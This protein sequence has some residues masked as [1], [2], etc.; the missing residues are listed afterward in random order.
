MSDYT[1]KIKCIVILSDKSSGSS[2]LYRFLSLFPEVNHIKYTRHYENE[3]LYWTKA[4]SILELDQTKMLD[5][6]V[7]INKHQ[8]KYELKKFLKRNLKSFSF[9]KDDKEL[10]F[11]GWR[12]LCEEYAPVFIEKSP[13]HLHQWSCLELMMEFMQRYPNID[14]LFIGLVR[15]PMDTLYSHWKR[16]RTYPEKNQI[17]WFNAYKNLIALKN[18]LKEKVLILR[19]EDF[20]SE[21]EHL[22]KVIDFIDSSYTPPNDYFYK[23]SIQK[24]KSDK[25]FGFKLHK[26]VQ[27]FAMQ[28][29]YSIDDLINE[30][31][32]TWKTYRTVERYQ[33]MTLQRPKK[34]IKAIVKKLI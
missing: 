9:P 33:Y 4:A 24:W 8:S 10:V 22:S 16:W 5:S 26:D 18:L 20:I 25:H 12:S 3:T 15:N 29:G 19:Y 14:V 23:T 6:E 30:P 27:D 11:S 2:A 13:H 21:V 7:P 32:T 1:T 17:Q 28:F 31:S 34:A